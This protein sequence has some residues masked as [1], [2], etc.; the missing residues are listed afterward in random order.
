MT[1]PI[2]S[3]FFGIFIYMYWRDHPSPH[4]YAKYG[5][6]EVAIDIISGKVT[7]TIS[8]KALDLIQV[9]RKLHKIE[10]IEAWELAEKKKLL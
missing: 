10:L 6:E 5:I 2:I 1:M 3:R 9:W 7:G 8:Q 4:F